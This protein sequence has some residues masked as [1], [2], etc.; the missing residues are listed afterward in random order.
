MCVGAGAH[1]GSNALSGGC[2]SK[3]NERLTFNAAASF[4]PANQEYQGTDNSWSG[5]AGFIFK[6][7][8]V[9]KPTL[10]S[11]KEKKELKAE[12]KNLKSTNQEL[13]ELLAMQNQKLTLQNERLEKLE[14]IA[15]GNF[16]SKELV[17]SLQ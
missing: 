1:S 8:K 9:T 10:I 6:L 4:I 11:M 3:I 16:N 17:S 5:R 7:G 12:V 2:A 14:Q 13:K 15:L